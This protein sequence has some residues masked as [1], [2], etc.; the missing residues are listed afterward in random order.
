MWFYKINDEEFGPVSLDELKQ[1]LA[2]KKITGKTLLRSAKGTTWLPLAERAKKKA[3]PAQ[4]AS[5]PP[6]QPSATKKTEPVQPEERP[7]K[8]TAPT[9]PSSPASQPNPPKADIPLFLHKLQPAKLI[10]QETCHSNS[11]GQ[12]VS[13]LKYGLLT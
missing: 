5:A 2:E 4:A 9:S 13:I 7:E 3:K 1:L 10:D 8:E 12:A 6:K 11:P